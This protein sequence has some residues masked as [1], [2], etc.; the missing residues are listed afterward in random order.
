MEK[1]I[2]RFIKRAKKGSIKTVGQLMNSIKTL[3]S[4]QKGS[5]FEDYFS[6]FIF[7]NHPYFESLVAGV[8]KLN[9]PD[10]HKFTK[11]LGMSEKDIGTDKIIIYKN[12]EIAFVQDKYRSKSTLSLEEIS[13]FGMQAFKQKANHGSKIASNFVLST[14]EELSRNLKEEYEN[15]FTWLLRNDIQELITSYKKLTGKNLFVDFAFF[16]EGKRKGK[17]KVNFEK[18]D[19]RSPQKDGTYESL[20]VLEEFDRVH[21]TLPP[22]TGKTL[23]G[24]EIQNELHVLDLQNNQ[25]KLGHLILVPTNDLKTQ[26]AEEYLHYQYHREYKTP[27]GGILIIGK[28]RKHPSPLVEEINS[29]INILNW[30]LKKEKERT[31]FFVSC[32]Y[33]SIPKLEE[34]AGLYL[35]AKG[36]PLEFSSC[37]YDECHRLTGLIETSENSKYRN[38]V[39]KWT[40]LLFDLDHLKIR[41]RIFATATP[42]ELPQLQDK[43]VE[44]LDDNGVTGLFGME[45][46]RVFGKRSFTLTIS[47]AQ[48]L[49]LLPGLVICGIDGAESSINN[50]VSLELVI[51]EDENGVKEKI[52]TRH[53]AVAFQ[54][55]K[56]LNEGKIKK[57]IVYSS[58]NST[59]IAFQHLLE[60]YLGRT[61]FMDSEIA[62]KI[63]ITAI[64]GDDPSK[65]RK[66]EIRRVEKSEYAI[67]IN[68]RVFGEGV[69]I[70]SLD[71]VAFLD[72]RFS[73]VDIIQN[74]LRASNN[75]NKNPVIILPFSLIQLPKSGNWIYEEVDEKFAMIATLLNEVFGERGDSTAQLEVKLK[76]TRSMQRSRGRATISIEGIDELTDEQFDLWVEGLKLAMIR[77]SSERNIFSA[78]N[79]W[80]NE[81]SN[82]IISSFYK[83]VEEGNEPIPN[84]IHSIWSEFGKFFKTISLSSPYLWNKKIEIPEE[85]ERETFDIGGG[86]TKPFSVVEN[87]GDWLTCEI[88]K[89]QND[90]GKRGTQDFVLISKQPKD[91]SG[92][93]NFIDLLVRGFLLTGEVATE[94][95]RLNKIQ[96]KLSNKVLIPH[97][98]CFVKSY[99]EYDFTFKCLQEARGIAIDIYNSRAH[100]L[101]FHYSVLR[102]NGLLGES[103]DQEKWDGIVFEYNKNSIKSG[104]N[105]LISDI[106]HFFFSTKRKSYGGKLDLPASLQQ[107]ITNSIVNNNSKR[108]IHSQKIPEKYIQPTPEDLVL[109][110]LK[111]KCFGNS[112]KVLAKGSDFRNN[113]ST[114]NWFPDQL[115]NLESGEEANKLLQSCVDEIQDMITNYATERLNNGA[116]LSEVNREFGFGGRGSTIHKWTSRSVKPR[117]HT[118]L[119]RG[120]IPKTLFPTIDN[121]INKHISINEERNFNGLDI[122]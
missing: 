32:T 3:D 60:R 10:A 81:I 72:P 30:I 56:L 96:K 74:A 39:K 58:T 1:E 94:A 68:C 119:T 12:G 110:L 8:Y 28:D 27:L 25:S 6:M 33:Q 54:I 31:K 109:V 61:G 111:A 87:M 40:Q 51:S 63:Y 23:I 99:P 97:G 57:V 18:W 86:I 82:D 64:T 112:G 36:E 101:R 13:T 55:A 69:T 79:S 9:D 90:L 44:Y 83:L 49:G 70:K 122:C 16:L 14:A 117:I 93:K 88:S 77:T 4:S 5:F 105:F 37:F 24:C 114:P 71:S 50:E 76:E 107:E 20:K 84:I 78:Y 106:R 62:D 29:P 80:K 115:A 22:R 73:K 11:M 52:K 85:H 45:N 35:K 42:K 108:K 43:V 66:S 104:E 102:K 59:S 89:V 34:V 19:L 2:K 38:S 17:R 113:Q 120:Q 48:D 118:L 98:G 95:Y 7:T 41:K 103:F 67:L 100:G 47:E 91:Y 21:Y 46:E 121:I 75:P 15:D 26:Q 92:K 65:Y 53:Q 116:L